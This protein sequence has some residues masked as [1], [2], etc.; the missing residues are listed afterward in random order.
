MLVVVIIER[1][2]PVMLRGRHTR[3]TAAHRR[4]FLQQR[5]RSRCAHPRTTD[6]SHQGGRNGV[7]D[8]VTREAGADEIVDVRDTAIAAEPVDEV[9]MRMLPCRR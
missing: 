7:A 6:S 5:R 4:G 9:H 8:P 3:E 1:P 2:Q